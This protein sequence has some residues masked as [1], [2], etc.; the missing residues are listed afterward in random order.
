[1]NVINHLDIL[2]EDLENIARGWSAEFSKRISMGAKPL[3]I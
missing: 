2:L 3:Q 1:M